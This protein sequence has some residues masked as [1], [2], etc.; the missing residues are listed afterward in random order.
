[1][2]PRG[3]L[4]LFS[5]CVEVFS[6]KQPSSGKWSVVLRRDYRQFFVCSRSQFLREIPTKTLCQSQSFPEGKKFSWM[7]SNYHHQPPNA[8]CKQI[9]NPMS[10]SEPADKLHSKTL[11]FSEELRLQVLYKCFEC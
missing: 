5:G 9:N 11:Q 1:M 2:A 8:V 10:T 6:G 3:V 4:V 7:L